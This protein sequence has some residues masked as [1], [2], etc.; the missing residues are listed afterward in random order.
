MDITPFVENLRAD[1]TNAAQAAGPEAQA[2]ADR[3]GLALEP[4]MRLGLLDA[5]TQAAAEICAELPAGSVEVRLRGRD[6]EFVV[7]VPAPSMAT[8]PPDPSDEADEEEDDSAV[9]RITLRIP[10]SLKTRAEELASKGGQSLNSWI[11]AALRLATREKAVNID[12][13]LASLPFFDDSRPGKG[14]GG[15]RMTGWQ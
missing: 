7:D 10:E 6:P 14:Q 4:A 3:M 9:A 11:V 8:A 13:D 12:I 1:L 15:R 2:A 5:L